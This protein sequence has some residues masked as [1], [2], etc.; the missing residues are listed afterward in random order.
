M[1]S[2]P[3]FSRKTVQSYIFFVFFFWLY[4]VCYDFQ[5][6]AY[7]LALADIQLKMTNMGLLSRCNITYWEFINTLPLVWWLSGLRCWQQFL[8]HLWCDPNSHCPYHIW[9]FKLWR[10]QN[11]HCPYHIWLFKL[12][13]HQN[14]HCPL[15]YMAIQTMET[16]ECSV[17]TIM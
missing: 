13:R 7:Q 1:R 10:H 6:Q 12:W 17:I 3:F 4:E 16:P 2:L 15:S 11:T 5:T 9:L 8:D 14:T